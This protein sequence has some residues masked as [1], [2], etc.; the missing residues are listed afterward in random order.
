M[1]VF[2]LGGNITHRTVPLCTKIDEL[3][4]LRFDAV[5]T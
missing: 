2:I 5:A 1:Q 3:H 4:V